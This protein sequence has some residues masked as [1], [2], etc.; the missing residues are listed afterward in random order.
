MLRYGQSSTKPFDLVSERVA[1]NT[2][3]M[4]IGELCFHQYPRRLPTVLYTLTCEATTDDANRV[5]IVALNGE[6][7]HD[8][9]IP[10]KVPWNAWRH[11][12]TPRHRIALNGNLYTWLAYQ[13]REEHMASSHS[14]AH[15]PPCYEHC[16]A[17][18][19]HTSPQNACI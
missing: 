11:L 15:Q 6:V 1:Y 10:C 19:K 7:V 2:Q 17:L 16:I 4:S 9:T 8:V 14:W 13:E 3:S 5:R 18:M 12:P